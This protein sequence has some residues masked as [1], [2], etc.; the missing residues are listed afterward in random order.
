MYTLS[1]Q[2]YDKLY[3]FK[4][5]LD[6]VNKLVGMLD[7]KLPARNRQLLDVACGT[8]RHLE[9][10]R[11]YFQVAGMDMSGDMLSQARKRLPGVPFY[12]G[13]L[14]DFNLGLKFNV[15]TCLFSSIGYLKTLDRVERAVR[16]MTN[17]LKPGGMLVVEPWLTP[18]AWKPGTVHA[19]LVE[20]PELKIARI[21]TSMQ[22]G[23]LSYFDMH[24]LVGTPQGTEHLVERHEMGLFETQELLE[25]FTAAG[26]VAS[27]DPQGLTG[28][29]LL[30]GQK[31]A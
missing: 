11:N 20:E 16:C 21:S 26:L 25:I 1:A 28:R 23:K 17:H 6:E 15:V 18:E 14:A 2:Y 22:D 8:G 27:F 4:D 3:S 7:E 19:L 13:D 12:L 10:L 5:Y 24:Y 31:P 9:F 29:G 30:I